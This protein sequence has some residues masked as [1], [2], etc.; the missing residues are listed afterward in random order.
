M[1]EFVQ[2]SAR[3]DA[4]MEGVEALLEFSC[5]TFMKP[6]ICHGIFKMQAPVVAEALARKAF[7]EEYV[8]GYVLGLCPHHYHEENL[9]DFRNRVLAGKP[10]TFNDCQQVLYDK[11]QVSETVKVVHI[12]DIHLD[13]LYTPETKADC[14][15]ALCCR[16]ESGYPDKDEKPAGFY[17]DFM[18]DIPI[19]TA[20]LGLESI[21]EIR[22]LDAIIWTGDN[23][24]HDIWRLTEQEIS[25]INERI[26]WELQ[27]RFPN[28]VILPIF[29]NHEFH[30]P[31][32]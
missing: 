12:T 29:G 32:N 7:S 25:Q 27:Y 13:P 1:A 30:P 21:M 4:F 19:W 8:C 26:T 16:P 28:K 18:C 3:N 10:C 15:D 31:N 14:S 2:N 11:M 24:P 5:S 17:G 9:D 6:E 23:V 20:Q 22:D